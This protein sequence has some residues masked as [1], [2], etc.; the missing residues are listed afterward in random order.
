MQLKTDFHL[1]TNDDNE[2]PI[3]HSAIELIEVA[4]SKGFTT[5][6]ITNHNTYTYNNDLKNYAADKGMLLIPGIEKSIQR[7][8]VLILNAFP[9][10]KKIKT[11]ADLAKAKDDGIF[12]IAPHPFFKT[13]CCL[14]SVLLEHIE[15]FDALEFSYFYSRRLNLNKR[16]LELSRTRRLPVVGNSDCHLLKYMG[17]CH[18]VIQAKSHAIED[19][20]SAIRARQVNVV[21]EPVF[22]PKLATIL[23]EMTLS[24]YK[25]LL[26]P[27]KDPLF[28][29]KNEIE[30]ASV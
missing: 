27:E 2:D 14:G 9:A 10:V 6:A 26:Q 28:V 24:K 7:K 4:A 12:V 3:G 19:V 29:P 25:R 8:H 16:V 21:S 1:H 17:I 30:Q 23:A 5:L 13:R 18:S 15:L 20:F 11:F 22:L